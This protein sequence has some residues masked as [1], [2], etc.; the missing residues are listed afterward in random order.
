MNLQVSWG[1]E[2]LP[3]ACHEG[4]QTL[5]SKREHAA[6]TPWNRW[7]FTPVQSRCK[8]LPTQNSPLIYTSTNI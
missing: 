8:T 4:P 7:S 2:A 6:E 3:F 1:L 5:P